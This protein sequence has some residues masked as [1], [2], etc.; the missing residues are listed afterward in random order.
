MLLPTLH[1]VVQDRAAELFTSE[2][3]TTASQG[4]LHF[5]HCQQ[6]DGYALHGL[7]VVGNHQVQ[8]LI[9][10]EDLLLNIL[11]KYQKRNCPSLP[12][13]GASPVSHTR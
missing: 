2:L 6:Q 4:L 10:S 3:P 8:S 5:V 11:R 13:A 7:W 1:Q 9:E 12:A